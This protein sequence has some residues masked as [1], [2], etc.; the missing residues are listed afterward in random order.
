[1]SDRKREPTEADGP[2]FRA[3]YERAGEIDD[4][5]TPAQR[6][7]SWGGF[8]RAAVIALA[9]G[10]LREAF[11]WGAVL[12]SLLA[13]VFGATGGDVAWM[14]PMIGVGVA[15]IGL[16]FWALARHWAFGR[17]W[18][19]LLGVATVQIVVIVVFWRTH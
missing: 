16:V 2:L 3:A 10:L 11:V 19:V 7:R 17:Q 5:S 1:M 12:F 9:E 8:L 13:V 6:R 18:A 4:A 15:G 14:I